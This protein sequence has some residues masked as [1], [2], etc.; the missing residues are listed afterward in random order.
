MG[1]E[2]CI[3]DRHQTSL[4]NHYGLDPR[5]PQAREFLYEQIE[6]VLL[7]GG[8]GKEID[9]SKQGTIDWAPPGG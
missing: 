7:Q 8:E 9:T 2:M 1:S 4:I 5:E 6:K 3:R